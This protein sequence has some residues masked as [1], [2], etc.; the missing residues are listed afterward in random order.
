MKLYPL[1][2]KNAREEIEQKSGRKVI[3]R[4]NKLQLE[5]NYK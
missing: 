2:L 4:D 1:D 5:N 3:F